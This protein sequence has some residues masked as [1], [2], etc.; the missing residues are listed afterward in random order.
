MR[1]A[2]AALL[3]LVASITSCTAKA[4]Q[5]GD[6][7]RVETQTIANTATNAEELISR[8]TSRITGSEQA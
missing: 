4:A 5:T 1:K 2:L 6:F 7:Y 8:S 3:C